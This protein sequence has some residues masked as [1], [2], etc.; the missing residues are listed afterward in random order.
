MIFGGGA[1]GS[2]RHM[3]QRSGHQLLHGENQSED[4]RLHHL[5]PDLI[6]ITCF[7]PV[8]REVARLALEH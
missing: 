5:T 4:A 3:A 8:R 2:D 6:T 1:C 7:N